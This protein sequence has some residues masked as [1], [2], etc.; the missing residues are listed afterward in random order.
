MKNYC[1]NK[2]NLQ[3]HACPV[4]FYLHGGSLNYDS[5]VMFDDQYITDRYSSKDVVFV[6]S[7]F[8]LGIFGV[9]AFADDTVV[10]RNLA[11]YDI[12]AGL[13]MMHEEIEAFG[14]DPMRVTLMGHSQGA[15]IAVVFAVS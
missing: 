12:V 1:K 4:V 8:R 13:E 6:I 15:S 7:A 5:A 3:K 2:E 9:S 14:G 10:P 11:L